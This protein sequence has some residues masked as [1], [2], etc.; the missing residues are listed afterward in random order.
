[1]I[2]RSWQFAQFEFGVGELPLSA[3]G[4]VERVEG[5]GFGVGDEEQIG[6]VLEIDEFL[7]PV[8]SDER[9]EWGDLA[10]AKTEPPI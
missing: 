2:W 10:R 5:V 3:E 4:G 8:D 7:K 1:M 9:V 6:A